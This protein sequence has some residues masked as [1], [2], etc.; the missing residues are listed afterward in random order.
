M[1]VRT[2]FVI[3]LAMLSTVCHAVESID[4]SYSYPTDKE[5]FGYKKAETYD[6][7]IRIVNPSLTGS[8]IKSIGVPISGDLIDQASASGWISTELKLEKNSEGKR[9]NV[10]DIASVC[11]TIQG[12]SLIAE[13]P[14]SVVM[15][16]EGLYVGYSFTVVSELESESLPVI[17]VGSVAEQNIGDGWLLHASKSL[18]KWN[19]MGSQKELASKLNVTFAGDFYDNSASLELPEKLWTVQN[20]DNKI[21]ATISN[22]GRQPIESI[23]YTYEIDAQEYSGTHIFTEPVAPL[24]GYPIEFYP[25]IIGLD[26]SGWQSLKM[27]ITQVN[28]IRN[29]DLAKESLA[30]L[31]FIPFMPV[32]RP[33]VE[34]Y[35]GLWCGWCPSGYVILEQ[36]YDSYPENFVGISYHTRDVMT[37]CEDNEL[38][39]SFASLP[40]MFINRHE[41]YNPLEMKRPWDKAI[42][43][44]PPVEMSVEISN[45]QDSIIEVTC[46]TRFINNYE[47]SNFKVSYI[48]IADNL[49]NTEWL[50]ANYYNGHTFDVLTGPYS[51]IF[52][53]GNPYI[54]DLRYDH[55]G[56]ALSENENDFSFLPSEISID[57]V[58]ET[59]Y[60]FDVSEICN[61]YGGKFFNPDTRFRIIAVFYDEEGEVCTSAQSDSISIESAS[62][63]L[64][65]STDAGIIA[66]NAYAISG[67]KVDP[68]NR[69]VYIVHTQYSDGTTKV[70]KVV[71]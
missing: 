35:T 55:V 6:V 66:R 16:E 38:P 8:K 3:F 1:N 69:G 54:S 11:A 17:A 9:V 7:A 22:N 62:T 49:H 60:Q 45:P 40:G 68:A 26:F 56:I 57:E 46:T 63:P 33:L 29:Y 14:E 53:F 39:S 23:G 18:I 58:Y 10:P 24:F 64:M 59:N 28:G 32:S 34:E 4:F 61:I 70:E 27:S 41:E 67:Y 36:M 2:A 31:D 5:W 65:T 30:D 37:V 44:V 19:N 51:D 48:L 47:N 20:S 52:N 21:R 25:E 15:P 43:P 71:R 13:F 50:Q 12:D 42:I